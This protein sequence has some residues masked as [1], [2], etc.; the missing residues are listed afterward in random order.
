MSA[1]DEKQDKE[2][3]CAREERRE[4][5][6]G[7]RGGGGVHFKKKNYEEGTNFI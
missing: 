4:L 5:R 1:S 7:R 6:P 2:S 3:A